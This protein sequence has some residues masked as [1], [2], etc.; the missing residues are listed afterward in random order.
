MNTNE[1][2]IISICN[3]K[4]G[5]AKTTS[6]YNIA[7]LSALSGRKTLMIDLDSQASLTISTGTEPLDFENNIATIFDDIIQGQSKKVDVT[8]AIYPVADIENL[9]IIPSIIDL[10]S[11]ETLL[12]TVTAKEQTLKRILKHIKDDYDYI[13]IDCGPSLGNLTINALSASDLVLIPTEADYLSYRGL[14]DLLSVVDTIKE[15]INDKLE[16]VGV[17][18]TK[19]EPQVKDANDVLA[20]LQKQYNVLG[21]V[22]KSVTIKNGIYEGLPLAINPKNKLAQEIKDEYVKIFD[23]IVATESR[24]V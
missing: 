15:L 21:I 16:V 23:A 14:G 24:G 6:T 17:I 3:Q 12:N 18:V 20:Q 9:F 13:F 1:N 8:K 19:F 11:K 5:V 22:K 10:A 4:G 7:T 2:K